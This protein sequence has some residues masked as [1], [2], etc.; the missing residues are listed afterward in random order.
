MTGQS[1]YYSNGIHGSTFTSPL[2]PS[3]QGRCLTFWFVNKYASL[4]LYMNPVG[5][6]PKLLWNIGASGDSIWI[7]AQVT[8]QSTTNFTVCNFLFPIVILNTFE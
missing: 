5:F 1:T 3:T 8:V 4:K 7:Y 2:Y 6:D